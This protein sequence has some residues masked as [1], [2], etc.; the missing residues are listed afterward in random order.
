MAPLDFRKRWR[1]ALVVLIVTALIVTAFALRDRLRDELLDSPL[2]ARF[3]AADR[4]PSS[5]LGGGAA[6]RPMSGETSA[7][8]AP[9]TL[10][11]R[12]RQLIGVRTVSVERTSLRRTIRTVG[13]V[14]YDETKVTDVNLKVGGWI[15]EL[16]VNYTG[17]LVERGQP[18]LSIYSPDLLATQGE[19]LLAL[20][21]RDDLGGSDVADAKSH[22]E[23]LVETARRRLAL[24]DLSA[25]QM[26]T[27]ERTREPQ[28]EVLFRAPA[29]GYVIEKTA[30]QGLHVEPGRSLFRIA[31][32]SEVWVEADVYEQD[33]AVVRLGARAEVTLD[34]YPNE[35]FRGEIAYVYP[36]VDDATRSVKVRLAF[37]NRGG[38]LK[39]GMYANVEL[40]APL[41]DGLVVPTNALL[42]SGRDQFVFVATGDGYFE[43]RPVTIGQRL[44]DGVQ[45]LE[46]LEEH[47][48]VASGA[49]F[50]LDSESQLRASLQGFGAPPVPPSAVSGDRDRLTIDFRSEPDPPRSGTNQFEVAVRTSDGDPVT[51]AQ[52][53]VTF[54]MAAMPTMN[55][56]AMRSE[57]P[58]S[59][60]DG[61]VYRGDGQVSMSGRW[62]V[63]VTVL[64]G[65]AQLGARQLSVV[66]R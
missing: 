44:D 2:V 16:H 41:G 17:Q 11:G 60:A 31:D 13:L 49:T 14:R 64:R 20:R 26:E 59:H 61:G 12:R 36:F 42:D 50:F 47:E 40:Q 15:R 30:I 1:G 28:P 22:A 56:P 48:L 3:F 18:L 55:M 53:M 62:D 4:E 27:L 52:V 43:P 46:G 9:F 66:A 7:S 58:L 37:A 33:S 57:A 23:R 35:R 25:D 19:L 29:S 54:F 32:L 5:P 63:T 45:I 34:A 39:P 6:S 38:R 21:A 8:R 10:D 24:W 65:G 51:D